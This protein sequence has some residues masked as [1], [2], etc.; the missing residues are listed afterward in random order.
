M[1]KTKTYYSQIKEIV[2]PYLEHYRNDLLVHDKEA[3]RGYTGRLLHFSRISGTDLILLDDKSYFIAG[4]KGKMTREH[5]KAY[6]ESKMRYNQKFLTG[7]DGKVEEISRELMN[8]VIDNFLEEYSETTW[9]VKDWFLENYT[10]GKWVAEDKYTG[11]EW[12][13]DSR[14]KMLARIDYNGDK[15]F[16]TKIDQ[17][18]PCIEDRIYCLNYK[19]KVKES[20]A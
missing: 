5:A 6:F 9:T 18:Y 8:C 16:Q 14:T 19:K 7:K 3:L 15:E 4:N 12:E 11:Y 17:P 2:D 10:S 1:V 20:K 13:F